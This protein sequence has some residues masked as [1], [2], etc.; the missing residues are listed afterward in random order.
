MKCR[1]IR[2]YQTEV[3][4]L[5]MARNF[6]NAEIVDQNIQFQCSEYKEWYNEDC[7]SVKEGVCLSCN[8]EQSYDN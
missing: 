2:T 1:I 3:D 8:A 5:S 4:N 7:E 6:E